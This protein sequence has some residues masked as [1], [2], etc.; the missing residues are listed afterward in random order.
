M[1]SREEWKK[2][3]GKIVVKAWTDEEFRMRLM[4]DPKC[5]FKENGIDVPDNVEI[6]VV[7]NTN[8]VVHLTLPPKPKE[9]DL[10]DKE[11]EKIAGGCTGGI[12]KYEDPLC[13]GFCCQ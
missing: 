12:V 2:K 11:L 8:N 5:V 9:V 3:Y 4:S 7:E 1:A 6:K 13:C 10:S